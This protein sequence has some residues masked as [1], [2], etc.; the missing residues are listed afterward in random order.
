MRTPVNVLLTFLDSTPTAL[1]VPVTTFFAV[2]TKL[3][4]TMRVPSIKTLKIF[5]PVNAPAI[6]SVPSIVIL[7][8][9][10]ATPPIVRVPKSTLFTFLINVPLA[11]NVPLGVALYIPSKYSNNRP[12]L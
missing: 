4:D 1:S 2:L 7:Y 11:F 8:S 12:K 10:D 3:P 5:L 6:L 9:F